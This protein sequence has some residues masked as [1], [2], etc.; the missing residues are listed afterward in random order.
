MINKISF[1]I[2]VNIDSK[3][4]TALFS[5]VLVTC[6]ITYLRCNLLCEFL[7]DFARFE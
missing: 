7:T 5:D 4:R 1:A 2:I 3:I 6:R